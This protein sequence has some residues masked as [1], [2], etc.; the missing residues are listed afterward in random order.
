MNLTEARKIT[1]TAL[2]RGHY[3]SFNP[4]RVYVVCPECKTEVKAD[5]AHATEQAVAKSL[6][7][8]LIQHLVE[9]WCE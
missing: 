8:N 2:A 4:R 5:N 9:G 3:L 7:S 6:R 1:R